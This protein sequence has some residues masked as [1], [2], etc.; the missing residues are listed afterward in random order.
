MN[1]F[2]ILWSYLFAAFLLL[3]ATVFFGWS[4]AVRGMLVFCSIIG[5]L[6]QRGCNNLLSK[7]GQ[8]TGGSDIVKND[9][10][11]VYLWLLGIW[12]LALI[13]S[14]NWKHRNTQIVKKTKNEE[15]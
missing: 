14:P 13:L 7:L 11:E 12:A 4:R 6:F 5:I 2:T 9:D 10:H 1:I 15:E 3:M 8:A